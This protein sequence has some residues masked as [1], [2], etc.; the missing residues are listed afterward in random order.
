MA[1][2]IFSHALLIPAKLEGVT[3]PANLDTHTTLYIRV[4]L[5]GRVKLTSLSGNLEYGINS[6]INNLIASGNVGLKLAGLDVY[7][8]VDLDVKFAGRIKDDCKLFTPM[9]VSLPRCA[10][11]FLTAYPCTDFRCMTMFLRCVVKR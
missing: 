11:D 5:W 2:V 4:P 1:F 10:R 6:S 3:D 7:I 9:Y 8:R